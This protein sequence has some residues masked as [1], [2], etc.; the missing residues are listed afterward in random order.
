MANP[1]PSAI[2]SEATPKV[3]SVPAIGIDVNAATRNRAARF[4]AEASSGEWSY[5]R[6][7]RWVFGDWALGC[8]SGDVGTA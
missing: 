5:G 3:R 8:C 6:G 7:D 2:A 4:I 1:H